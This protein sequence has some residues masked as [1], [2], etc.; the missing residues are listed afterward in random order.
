[1]ILPLILAVAGISLFVLAIRRFGVS[2]HHRVVSPPGLLTLGG[3][4][5]L[6]IAFFLGVAQAN[7]NRDRATLDESLV[8]MFGRLP[9][10]TDLE[11]SDMQTFKAVVHYGDKQF[12]LKT[13]REVSN[14]QTP[15]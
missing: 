15:H 12:R 9:D 8:K 13:E 4:A 2:R 7:T 6:T 11:G 5:L 3:I 1:M 10:R 14:D